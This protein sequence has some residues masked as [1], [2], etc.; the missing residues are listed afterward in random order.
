MHIDQLKDFVTFS[1]TRN[2]TKTAQQRNTTQPNVSKRIRALEHWMGISLLDR[3]QRPVE[4]T[5]DGLAFLPKAIRVLEQLQQAQTAKHNAKSQAARIKIAMPHSA[6]THIL[7]ALKQR[8]FHS[9]TASEFSMWIGNHDDVAEHLGRS[10]CDLAL[11]YV[12]DQV[13]PAEEFVVYRPVTVARDELV[14]VRHS[15]CADAS[16]QSLFVPHRQTYLGRVWQEV[17]AKDVNARTIEFGLPADIRAL[18]V[19]GEGKG[20]LPLSVVEQDLA[21]GVLAECEGSVRIP[22]SVNLYCSTRASATARMIWQSMA[23]FAAPPAAA[24]PIR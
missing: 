14:M 19:A 21:S 18:C 22:Y 9:C 12:H 5:E 7:P 10:E 3:D 6:S 20:V 23:D 11:A 8:F 13:G 1:E 17:G 2:F 16:D 4:L 15:T 24:I